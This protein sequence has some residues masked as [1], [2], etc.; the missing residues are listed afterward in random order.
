MK[1]AAGRSMTLGLL[2]A[3]VLWSCGD[4]DVGDTGIGVAGPTI[5]KGPGRIYRVESVSF[6]TVDEI[7]VGALFGRVE[8]TGAP[9]E[10]PAS[11]ARPVVI[12]VHDVSL[13]NQQWFNTPIFI[14]LLERG[15]LVLA[16]D[17]RGH[18]ASGLPDDRFTVQLEDLENSFLDI[19]AGLNWLKERPEAD[20]G[21]VA[22]VGSGL[23]GNV[24]YVS[25]GAF[26][27][28]IK[29]AVALSPGIFDPNLRAL[30]VGAG[31]ETFEPHTMLLIAG[32][33]DRFETQD[34]TVLFA[35]FA[36]FMSRTV[37][38]PSTLFVVPE[39]SAH[40]IE[41]LADDQTAEAFFSWSEEHL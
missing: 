1:N 39:S 41:L 38:D 3:F 40:G 29:T 18:G 16:V 33:D 23:G 31:L 12:L 15:Y 5:E 36:D 26:P 14:E 24:A 25:I 17:L 22:V 13:N 35:A 20:A 27:L 7:Q 2:T 28:E 10:G 6:S 11:G 21:R 37:R 19:R 9:G 4:D 32:E 8:V 30:V 34:Q